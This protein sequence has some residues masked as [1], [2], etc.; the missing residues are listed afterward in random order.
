[1]SAIVAASAGLGIAALV[2]AVLAIAR[3]LN[4][5]G[6]KTEPRDLTAVG[7]DLLEA[8]TVARMLAAASEGCREI[9]GARRTVVFRRDEGRWVAA[10]VDGDPGAVPAASTTA[11]AWFADHPRAVLA[12]DLAEPGLGAADPAIEALL[13]GYSID[14]LLPMVHRRRIIAVIGLAPARS[15]DRAALDRLRAMTAAACANLGLDREA[16]HALDLD[17][18]SD[19]L[20]LLR[21]ALAPRLEGGEVAG[22]SIAARSRIAGDIG[23]DFGLIRRRGD[24]LWLVIGDAVGSGLAAV[25]VASAVKGA[26]TLALDTGA[27]LSPDRLVAIAGLPLAHPG[28]QVRSSLLALRWLADGTI[29]WCNAGHPPPYVL[30]GAG[31]LEVLAGTGPLLGDIGAQ[32]TRRRVL[33][34]GDG[35]FAFTSGLVDRLGEGRD[36]V[37]HRKLQHLLGAALTAPAPALADAVDRALDAAPGEPADD[38]SF[39]AVRR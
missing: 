8:G 17:R 32:P 26:L 25:L 23:S 31:R 19:E 35:I 21:R 11:F 20:A 5:G 29:E 33:S 30:G 3:R 24:E 2:A 34:A 9:L 27:A 36:E 18:Q 6:H 7:A 1:V 28:A 14:A 15:G 37:G 22:A 39:V 16:V 12:A 10:A 4:E 13:A 38:I